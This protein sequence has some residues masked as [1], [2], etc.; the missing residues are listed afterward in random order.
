MIRYT[1]CAFLC[2]T[3]LMLPAAGLAA[4]EPAQTAMVAGQ[5]EAVT[6]EQQL[7]PLSREALDTLLEASKGKVVMLNFF[8][9]WCP[10][11]RE[12]LPGLVSLRKRYSP[13]QLVLVGISVDHDLNALKTFLDG[14]P[15]NYPV[16]VADEEVAYLYG[17]SS[18]PHNTVYNKAGELVGNQP[19]LIPEQELRRILDGLVK[20]K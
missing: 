8:A 17:V 7:E 18:I 19:G 12:E 13:D 5:K 3:G 4:G 1:L 11:C 14:M 2:L 6:A 15:L 16:Y 20:E 10:P 9:S